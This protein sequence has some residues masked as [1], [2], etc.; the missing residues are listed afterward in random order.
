MF[1]TQKK[2]RS[3]SAMIEVLYGCFRKFFTKTAYK[4]VN[5]RFICQGQKVCCVFGGSSRKQGAN[6]RSP[7]SMFC[8]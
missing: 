8:F 4:T 5:L 3:E 7:F 1:V 2:T 6:N